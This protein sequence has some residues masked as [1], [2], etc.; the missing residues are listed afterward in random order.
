MLLVI[1]TIVLFD[2]KVK[3]EVS[4][5]FLILTCVSLIIIIGLE[6]YYKKESISR[7]IIDPNYERIDD[8]GEVEISNERVSINQDL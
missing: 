6:I 2:C 5:S 4:I 7:F 8:F 1:I 3:Y